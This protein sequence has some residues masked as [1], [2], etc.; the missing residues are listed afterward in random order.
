MT[1]NV[2][3]IELHAWRLQYVPEHV[4]FDVTYEI[5]EGSAR[6]VIRHY[7]D[8]WFGGVGRVEPGTKVSEVIDR[9]TPESLAWRMLEGGTRRPWAPRVE[10]RKYGAVNAEVRQIKALL[11]IVQEQK[12]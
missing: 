3:P 9:V 8:V 12:L 7:D 11:K 5:F 2:S 6:I 10:D 4:T 1:I